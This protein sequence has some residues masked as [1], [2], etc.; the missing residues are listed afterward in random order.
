MT[1]CSK[2][3][4]QDPANFCKSALARNCKAY[5]RSCAAQHAREKRREKNG[6]H[7]R[8]ELWKR[9]GRPCKKGHSN[10]R[11]K[12]GNCRLCIAE[13]QKNYRDALSTAEKTARSRRKQKLLGWQA[14][15]IKHAADA[16]VR[17]GHAQPTIT[18]EWV[19]AQPLLCPYLGVHIVPS[20]EPY[21][22]WQPSLDRIDNDKGYEPSN[23]KLTCLL[24]NL[25]RN[26]MSVEQALEAVVQIRCHN[27][28]AKAA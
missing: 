6:G 11:N 28:P 1:E 21:S 19:K 20:E 8:T 18:V 15:L 17:R 27:T 23:V 14:R 2:C 24:W 22:P 26:R 25:M 16:S 13:G 5:C 12:R 4:D 9:A 3:G 10:A 7:T